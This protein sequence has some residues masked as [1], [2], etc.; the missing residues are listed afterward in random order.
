MAD[1]KIEVRCQGVFAYLKGF[2]GERW[3]AM[4]KQHHVPADDEH[5][6]QLHVLKSA[7]EASDPNFRRVTGKFAVIQ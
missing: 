5:V 1:I 6:C 7:V 3:I 4:P 2:K